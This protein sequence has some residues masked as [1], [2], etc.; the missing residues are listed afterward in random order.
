MHEQNGTQNSNSS[1]EQLRLR[2]EKMLEDD[3]LVRLR[4]V[5][6]DHEIDRVAELLAGDPPQEDQDLELLKSY[7]EVEGQ[8]DDSRTSGVAAGS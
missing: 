5:F 1:A 8:G 2:L 4:K 7:K 6:S 3:K